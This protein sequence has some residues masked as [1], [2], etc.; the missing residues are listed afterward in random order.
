MAKE[1]RPVFDY[2]I[3]LAVRAVVCIVQAMSYAQAR[4]LAHALA[5][6]TYRIDR[7][8]REVAKENLRQSF[9]GRYSD[10]ELNRVVL[11]VYQ[12]FLTMIMEIAHLPRKLHVTNWRDYIE[13]V[14][15][16]MMLKAITS[17]RPLLI[18]TGH[19]GNWEM[20][21]FALGLLGF[22]TYA[23]ARVLDNPHLEQFLKRF[24]QKTGQKI[25][26]KKGDFDMMQELLEQGAVIATLADQDAGPK[27]LF[28][29]YFG[30]PASTYKSMALMSIEFN[31]PILVIGVPKVGEPMQYQVIAVDYIEPS[32]YANR[33]DALKAITQRFTTSLE[34]IV[35]QYPDQY[36]WLHRRWK[37]QPP[38]RKAKLAA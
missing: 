16:Q 26:A 7:R 29:E 34:S 14:N 32:E 36:F 8:H 23:V 1:R 31:V 13:L 38:V 2:A 10:D 28:V 21:G 24:R 22:K 17:G 35:Q 5:W 6:L 19:F 12:H 33:P 4:S 15:S 27:G 9:P 18:V 25:L 11:R 3:Y 30:R 20:A 37:H